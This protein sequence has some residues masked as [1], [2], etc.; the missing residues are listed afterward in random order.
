MNLDFASEQVFY[1]YTNHT[2]HPTLA[3]LQWW[4]GRKYYEVIVT[5]AYRSG[6]TGVHSSLPYFRGLDLRS[7]IFAHPEDMEKDINKV[8]FYDPDRP[9]MR[10]CKY[11]EVIDPKTNKSKGLHFHL[12]VDVRN[13]TYIG[14]N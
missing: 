10:C 13:T 7:Y 12:Q 11:H 3:E 2:M 6:G 9:K 4:F 1:N 5:S 8:W 14:G